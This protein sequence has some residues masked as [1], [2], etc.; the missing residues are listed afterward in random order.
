MLVDPLESRTLLSASPIVAAPLRRGGGVPV[1]PPLGAEVVAGISRGGT[2]T[3]LGTDD[4]DEI[5]MLKGRGRNY[6][7][8]A[9]GTPLLSFKAAAVKRIFAALGAGGDDVSL[10]S[11][12]TPATI[13]AGVGDDLIVG[14]GGNDTVYG[15]DGNDSLEGAL[16]DDCLYGQDGNDTLNG[17]ADRDSVLGGNG[18][19]TWVASVGFDTRLDIFEFED[20]WPDTSIQD[21]LTP[22]D[23]SA[24]FTGHGGRTL[25]LV[26]TTWSE[27]HVVDFGPLTEA[28]DG[29][30]DFQI[31]LG[32]TVP[33]DGPIVEKTTTV[34]RYYDLSNLPVGTYTLAVTDLT[35]TV[36]TIQFTVD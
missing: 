17:S 13:L 1:A 19:D 7:V 18:D 10:W 21:N 2:L 34:R 11:L 20:R 3:L 23:L 9:G 26:V 36:E 22:D 25:R 6:S 33:L 14:S 28:L 24:K 5:T 29:T 30:S 8:L 31:R 12:N 35:R 4:D 16:G 27:S 32:V 15:D